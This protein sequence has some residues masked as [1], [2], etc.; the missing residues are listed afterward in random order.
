MLYIRRQI[1]RLALVLVAVATLVGLA[2]AVAGAATTDTNDTAS[3]SFDTPAG[4][5]ADDNAVA[6]AGAVQADCGWITCTV[7]LDRNWTRNAQSAAFIVEHG[8][9]LCRFIPNGAVASACEAFVRWKAGQF[10][11]KAHVYYSHGNCLGIKIPIPAPALA[12]P[13][14]VAHGY[15]NCR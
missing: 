13:V 10:A 4:V 2:P 14:S 5:L 1:A 8:A 7:R 15:K 9:A 3:I 6:V 11:S 12:Y